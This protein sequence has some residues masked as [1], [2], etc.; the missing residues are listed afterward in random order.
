ME[1][2]KIS[3]EQIKGISFNLKEKDKSHDSALRRIFENNGQIFVPT[4]FDL[5]N[6]KFLLLNFFDEVHVLKEMNLKELNCL[7]IDDLKNVNEY[8]VRIIFQNINCDFDPI[9][10]SKEIKKLSEYNSIDSISNILG[11]ENDIARF[12]HELLDFNWNFKTKKENKKNI[13][14]DQIKMFE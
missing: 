13:N 14:L 10:I 9:L 1:I 7:I 6:G 2:K 5:K 11:I 4:V 8:Y 12:Y 3:F